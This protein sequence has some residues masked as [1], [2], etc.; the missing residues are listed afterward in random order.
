VWSR[1]RVSL[2][3]MDWPLRVKMAALLV[4]ASLLPL[5]IAAVL[6]IRE[7]RRQLLAST[8]ALLAARGDHLVDEL[9]MFHRGYRRSA[10]RFA[11][12]PGVVDYCRA[13]FTGTGQINRTVRAILAVQPASDSNIRGAAIFDTAGTVRIATEPQLVG[14]RLSYRRYVREALRGTAA[15]SDIYLGVPQVGSVPT[16]AYAAP[17]RGPNRRVAGLFVIWVRA[18]SLWEI[19]RA[20]NELAGPRSF[21]VLFDHAGIRIAHTYQQDFVFHPGGRLDPATVD[22]LV[23]EHRFGGKTRAFLED[24]RAFPDQFDRARS[25]SPDQGL[26]RGF[27]PVN[28]QWNYGVGRRMSTVPWTLFY[29]IPEESLITQMTR[30]T[31]DKAVF[32]GVIILV[33]LLTG[34][35]FAAVILRPIG[36]LSA[37]TRALAGG[38]L[39]ARVPGHDSDELGRLGVSFNAMAGQ[40]EAQST[41]LRRARDELE[42]RVV[43]RTA[44]LV[45]TTKDLEAEVVERTRAE[46]ALRESEQ[47]LAT[48]LNS[49]GD[50]VIATDRAGRVIRMNPTAER[51]TGWPLA[52][53]RDRSLMEVFRILNEKTRQSAEDPVARVL[54]E[55]VVVGLANHTAL[56]ARDGSE[57]PIAD[58]GAPIRDAGGEIT[59]VVLVFRDQTDERKMEVTRLKSRELEAQSLRV[60]EAS[61]L[62]SQFLANMSHELRT[63]LNAIIGFSEL[64]HDGAVRP[65]MPQH[66]E[67]LGHILTSGRHLLQL[68]N[69]VLDLSKVEAGKLEFHPEAV[70]VSDL[71]G[72]VLGILRTTVASKAIRIETHVDPG[73]TD[74]VLDAAR[75]KQVLYNYI[76]NALKFTPTGGLVIVRAAAG[77]TSATFR[78]EVEDSG[79][80]VAPENIGRLFIEFQ[81]LDSGSARKHPGTGLGLALTK[82]LVEAQGGAVGVRS[83][84]GTGSTFHA[85]FPRQA[86]AGASI[87]EPRSFEGARAGAP[88]VLVIEDNERDQ[89]TLVQALTEAGYAVDTAATGAQALAKCRAQAFDAITLDLLLPDMSGLEVLRAIRADSRNH[90]VPVIVVTVVT[91]TGA[92][93]GFAVQDLLAKP[94]DSAALLAALR[95]AGVDSERSGVVLVVDDDSDSR[96][97]M[98]AT[99]G[100]LGYQSHGVPSGSDGLRVAGESPPLAV[101]LDLLMPEMD[102]F[103]FLVRFRRVPRCRRVPVI[104]WTVK[105]LTAEEHARLRVTAQG[106]IAKGREGST[107]VVDELRAFL[108][109]PRA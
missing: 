41:S 29:M 20:S 45:Q 51:L 96:E 3:F 101:V 92:V 31:R 106:V 80:G 46:D 86:P 44:E 32:A 58:S 56:I 99:L 37:A 12:L 33:A 23:S 75:L 57:R 5:A 105:D 102:G 52:E 69:D 87:P 13:G 79:I 109:E 103:E 11:R 84:A 66:Q 93:A 27:A 42:V 71:I 14:V 94:L 26:F 107:A 72:E 59:G 64:L 100:Q 65:E 70:N 39:T 4:A 61:R 63:P 36:S 68:I 50:A 76:S 90:D 18:A 30:L 77:D 104:V 34:T 40:I 19:A 55:G 2:R 1:M 9:D 97:L 108:P 16:I 91:E 28:Q 25:A 35:L 15:I 73:L 7:S 38:D 62:K 48:T 83:T 21:A 53:A 6:D 95:R 78:L 60:Q 67:F 8:A 17:V 10:I 85:V 24:I 89:A 74:I 54:R 49:I 88:V 98:A 43:E 47:S 22:S 82:R 81:Q